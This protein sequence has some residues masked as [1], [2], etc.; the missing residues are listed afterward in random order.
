MNGDDGNVASRESQPIHEESGHR[1][2]V[3]IGL[4]VG[5][6]QLQ[7]VGNVQP[8]GLTVIPQPYEDYARLPMVG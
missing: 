4:D 6:L 7:S 5:E 2:D 1:E 3:A 8:R